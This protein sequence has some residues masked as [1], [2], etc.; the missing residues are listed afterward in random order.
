MLVK[1]DDKIL[2]H[3]GFDDP[4]TNAKVHIS[5]LGYSNTTTLLNASV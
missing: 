5:L 4:V 2:S 1:I 3:L